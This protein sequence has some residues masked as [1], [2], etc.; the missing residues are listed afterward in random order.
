MF[1]LDVFKQQQNKYLF[2]FKTDLKIFVYLVN[3]LHIVN[4]YLVRYFVLII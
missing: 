3:A 4:I 2:K 1:I